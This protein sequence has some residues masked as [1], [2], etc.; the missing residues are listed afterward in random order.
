MKAV[1]HCVCG[2]L[3]LQSDDCAVFRGTMIRNEALGRIA[4]RGILEIR[5]LKD[6]DT[7]RTA[8]MRT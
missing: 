7:F 4:P 6:A 8:R 3:V 1:V 5:E 2:V